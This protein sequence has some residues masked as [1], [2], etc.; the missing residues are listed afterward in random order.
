MSL[1]K[2]QRALKFVVRVREDCQS[3]RKAVTNRLGL[4]TVKLVGKKDKKRLVYSTQDIEDRYTEEEEYKELK[5]LALNLMIQEANVEKMLH[6][7]LKQFDVYNSFL[8]T[9]KASG[10]GDIVSGWLLAECDVE[11]MTTVSKLWQYAGLNPGKVLGKKSVKKNEYKES[12]GEICSTLPNAKD[13]GERL[14]VR[15]TCVV[16]GDRPTKGYVLPY[17]KNLKRV[18]LGIL[19]MVKCKSHYATEF[20][21]PMKARL[22]SSSNKV[23][24]CGKMVPWKDVTK[25]HRDNAARRYMVKMFLKDF[26]VAWRTCE[27]LPVREPYAEEFLGKKHTATVRATNKKK[28]K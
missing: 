3:T 5:D 21:Y 19:N 20:Y 23:L 22:E 16:R 11:E 18:L 6:R 4:K 24:H 10:C 26:Y 8:N 15:T 2:E 13:G 9:S 14:L 17:N 25:A 12:M 27:G 28:V 7:V 1:T